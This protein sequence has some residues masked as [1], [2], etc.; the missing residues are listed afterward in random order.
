MQYRWDD[1]CFDRDGTLLTRKGQQIEVSRKVLDCASCLIEQ[2]HRVVGYAELIHKIWCHGDVTNHQLAQVVLATRRAFGDDGRSQSTIRNIPGSGYRWVAPVSEIS[3]A[4]AMTA[5]SG[6]TNPPDDPILADVMSVES[7]SDDLTIRQ[8]DCRIESPPNA[9][10]AFLHMADKEEPPLAP[11]PTALHPNQILPPPSSIKGRLQFLISAL[12]AVTAFALPTLQP[13]DRQ[14]APAENTQIAVAKAPLA[15]LQDRLWHG[16][17]E[18][19]RTG[20]ASLPSTLADSPDAKILE[21]RLHM[22]TGRMERARQKLAEEKTKSEASNDLV[23]RA[24]L[25]TIQSIIASREGNPD[26][27]AYEPARQ[28]V[29]LLESVGKGVPP[30]ILGEAYYALGESDNSL[31]RYE[32]AVRNLVIARDILIKAQDE[33]TLQETKRALAF[34]W[35]RN[36]RLTD[37]LDELNEMAASCQKNGQPACETN[38]RIIAA[39]I[40]IE[41]LRMEDA[42]Q[43]SRRAMTV[44]K[45][46]SPDGQHRYATVIQALTLT[47]IGRLREAAAL[48]EAIDSDKQ[49]ASIMYIQYLLATGENQR[50]LAASADMFHNRPENN[51]NLILSSQEG[52][53]LLWTI[54]AEGLQRNGLPA[55]SASQAQRQVLQRPQSIPGRIARGRWLWIEGEKQQA[56]TELRGALAESEKQKR[57]LYMTLAAEPLIAILLDRGDV[58]NAEEVLI[59]LRGMAPDEMDHSYRMSVLTLRT[60]MAKADIAAIEHASQRVRAL[61]GERADPDLSSASSVPTQR[62]VMIASGKVDQRINDN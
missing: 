47:E 58:A 10:G 40:Q 52:A 60:A 4:K 17:I 51:E 62:Q 49:P 35:Q 18:G 6:G 30:S 46:A 27:L 8:P 53:L 54:A 36:G 48:F 11:N 42:R 32:S 19:V 7:D 1:Y 13:R 41:L 2:R 45:I 57:I 21:I 20:L 24:R 29:D 50:A 31:G 59:S 55:P 26:P 39:R 37:A 33:I 61:I 3:G 5:V 12:L 43:N 9:G 14:P 25:L 56:E 16:D 28:A 15:V 44:S 38:A 23:W 34:A 22:Q